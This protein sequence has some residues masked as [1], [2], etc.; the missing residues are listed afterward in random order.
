MWMA[1]NFKTARATV[2]CNAICRLLALLRHP[3]MS[4]IRPLSGAQRTS[5]QRVIR[6]AIL[7]RGKPAGRAPWRPRSQRPFA[8]RTPAAAGTPQSLNFVADNIKPVPALARSL[9]CCASRCS[10]SHCHDAYLACSMCFC[11]KRQASTSRSCSSGVSMFSC[12]EHA[13]HAS[14]VRARVRYGV[15][16]GI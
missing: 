3:P 4:A 16:L 11:A 15:S 6:S 9:A 13:C 12:G 8:S 1:A 2:C 7:A 10:A 5:A 14:H